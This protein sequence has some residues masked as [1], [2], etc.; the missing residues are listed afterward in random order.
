[1][2][3]RR[4]DED[5]SAA[6]KMRQTGS[7]RFRTN[8]AM[9]RVDHKDP[10]WIAGPMKLACLHGSIAAAGLVRTRLHERPLVNRATATDD[11]RRSSYR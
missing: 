7:P 1:V 9:A 2:L 11:T 4:C 3:D 8:A 10:R 6:G 5:G